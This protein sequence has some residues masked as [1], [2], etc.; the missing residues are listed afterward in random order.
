[1]WVL[2]AYIPAMKRIVALLFSIFLVTPA[3]AGRLD[4]DTSDFI[5]ANMI[6]I[7]YHEFG[8]ALIDIMKLPIFGQE[9]DAADVLSA[10]LIHDFFAEE[11][12]QRIAYATAFGQLGERDIV[13][14]AKDNV[15]YWDVHGPD[16]QRYFTF[17]CLI[18]GANPEAREKLADELQ[19][20]KPRRE[21]CE[22][23]YALAKN[24]WGPVIDGLVRN[25]AGNTIRFLADHRV[26]AEGKLAMEVLQREVT[27]MNK[28]LSLPKRLLVR[29]ETC[30][31][32]NAFYEP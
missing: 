14:A 23:E 3:Q 2:R 19:L 26:D 24:S 22:D 20:P 28:D 12:A 9:E 7:Y 4:K 15:A 30:D 16:L 6:A 32:V 1:M 18:Y 17:V 29:V 25:G 8:H 10:V 27:A 13:S 5:A 11:T 21:T 31:T